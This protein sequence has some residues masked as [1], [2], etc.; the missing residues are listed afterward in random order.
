MEGELLGKEGEALW[1]GE[2]LPLAD[3]ELDNL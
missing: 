3:D 2:C 1:D